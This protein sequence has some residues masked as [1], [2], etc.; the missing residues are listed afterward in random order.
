MI[1]TPKSGHC[2]RI[3]CYSCYSLNL[4]KEAETH[5][6]TGDHT[7]SIM[8]FSGIIFILMVCLKIT[9]AMYII[10][11]P[12]IKFNDYSVRLKKEIASKQ[13]MYLPKEILDGLSEILLEID[14]NEE[15][16]PKPEWILAYDDDTGFHFYDA[17]IIVTEEQVKAHKQFLEYVFELLSMQVLL[18]VDEDQRQ[19][20]VKLL[21]PFEPKFYNDRVF[22]I[23]W[24]KI[25]EAMDYLKNNKTF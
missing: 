7:S 5:F 3:I 15:T 23:Y 2:Q 18:E 21:V 14:P 25:F 1:V 22:T 13:N 12:T 8:E 19:H 24:T 16:L 11:R 17:R 6:D 9:N 4:K 10:E 20:L